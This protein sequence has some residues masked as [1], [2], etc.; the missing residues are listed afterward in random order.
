MPD[1]L[2]YYPDDRPGITRRRQGR[3]FCYLAADGTRIDRG[4]ERERLE[5][6]AVPPAY[7]RVWMS[8]LPNGHLLATGFDA[9]SR[10]QYRYHPDWSAARAETKFASLAEFGALLPRIRRRVARDLAA[11]AGEQDFALAA[12]VTLIDRLA[13]RVGNED[14]LRQNGSDGALTLRRR[15]LRLGDGRIRL[16]FTAKGGRKVRRQIGDRR[17]LGLLEKARDLPGV[18][19][20]SWLD[21]EGRPRGLGSAA[22]NRYLAEAAGVEGHTAKTFRTWAGTRAAFLVAEPGGASVAAMARAAAESLYNTPAIARASYIHPK[23]IGLAD[24]PPLAI[25]APRQD[26]LT[27]AESRLL[28]FLQ[29]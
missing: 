25:D 27:G 13:L 4:P 24:G 19:L 22:L 16:S 12:A 23:V 26:R 10:K 7:R 6:M 28:A 15:H 8:P 2:I 11:E 5:R 17:L 20:L 18:E 14:Y 21:A 3:G 29:G 9:R 1:G